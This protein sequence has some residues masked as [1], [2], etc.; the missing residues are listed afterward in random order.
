MN[1]LKK[2]INLLCKIKHKPIIITKI[3]EYT[4]KRPFILFQI[5]EKSKY[6]EEKIQHLEL[7]KL[8]DFSKETNN[9]YSLFFDTLYCNKF[10]DEIVNKKIIIEEEEK[11]YF[12]T[13]PNINLLYDE[14]LQKLFD[15]YKIY[16]SN[17]SNLFFS[18]TIIEY[19]M[20]KPLISLSINLFTKEN[21]NNFNFDLTESDLDINYLKYINQKNFEIIKNQKFRLCININNRYYNIDKEGNQH[22]N[23]NYYFTNIDLIKNLKIEEIY[24]IR[25]TPYVNNRIEMIFKKNCMLEE[26]I[27][28]FKILKKIEHPENIVSVHFSDNIIKNISLLYNE[29]IPILDSSTKGN[30][31]NE[32]EISFKNLKN[33][34]INI[35]LLNINIKKIIYNFFNYNIFFISYQDIMNK[36]IINIINNENNK[37][38]LFNEE[39]VVYINLEKNIIYNNNLYEFFNKLFNK[40]NYSLID[41]IY[42]IV[43]VYECDDPNIVL[44]SHYE[45]NKLNRNC[46]FDC[47][48]PNLKEIIINNK[49]NKI[50]N[51]RLIEPNKIF[52]FISFLCSNSKSLCS[53]KLNDT[54]VPYNILDLFQKKNHFINNITNLEINSS[55]LNN[56]NYSIIIESINNCI[57]LSNISI[58]TMDSNFNDSFENIKISKNLKYIKKF[59]F[60][61][62]FIYI[63]N[64]CKEIE[65]IQDSN[66]D[67]ELIE[68]FS[69]IIENEESLETLKINGFHYNFD[70][71]KNINVKYIQINL[72][73][74]DKDYIINKIKFNN[75]NMK[76]NNFPNL[77]SIYVYVDILYEINNFIKMPICKELK[78]VFLFASVIYCD[79]NKLDEMLKENGVELIVRNIEN[80]NK[81]LILAYVSSF[82]MIN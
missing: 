5:I 51:K 47:I 37:K 17:K 27:I 52:N 31:I 15:R 57:N 49:T 36:N 45:I 60:N 80:F 62:F 4:L 6:L 63:N 44:K 8:N 41:K 26:L 38:I 21:N 67:K 23:N 56:Y 78:R 30:N 73:N 29:I 16:L 22:I 46:I 74:N 33:I 43:I 12:L 11:N 13:K 14:I 58:N 18:K 32:K 59:S 54:F 9:I 19:C 48:L 53:I 39:G 55:S 81:S 40:K 75:I 10:F 3:F 24:F 61:S 20:F 65:F 72:E 42:K 76:L 2:K 79:I 64:N 50:S 28:M 69:E 66:I 35:N 25:P 7:S 68:I 71:I 70:E 82:P 34:D 77:N 1:E